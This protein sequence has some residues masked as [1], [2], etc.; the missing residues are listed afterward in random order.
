MKTWL[1]ITAVIAIVSLGFFTGGC[2]TIVKSTTQ[3]ISV[4]SSPAGA[5]VRLDGDPVGRTPLSFKAKRKYDHLVTIEKAGYN[6]S[7]VAVT[8][9]IGGAVFGNWLLGAGTLGLGAVAG[10]GT[11]AASGAQYNLNPAMIIVALSAVTAGPPSAAASR[12]SAAVL[13]DDLQKL[14]EL[15]GAQKVSAEEYTK[16]RTRL[17]EAYSTLAPA[18]TG[19]AEQALVELK[20]LRDL[21]L[22]SEE[23]YQA[24][25]ALI[26]GK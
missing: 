17:V 1:K 6:P 25:R 20:R 22:I 9:S 3:T 15:R 5:D 21:Q 23:E 13:I 14:D 26:L 24:K 12:S 10:W 19:T 11:D 16:I 8:R 4:T 18:Q 7:Y 2:A